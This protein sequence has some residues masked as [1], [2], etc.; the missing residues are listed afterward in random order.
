MFSSNNRYQLLNTG[1]I[2]ENTVLGENPKTLASMYDGYRL[3]LV[4]SNPSTYADLPDTLAALA[5]RR[6][7]EREKRGLEKNKRFV[8]PPKVRP[9][10]DPRI[11]F[12]NK[13]CTAENIRFTVDDPSR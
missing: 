10:S 8:L 11:P 1:D 12:V 5:E 7:V 3:H 9:P 13:W 6:R 2:A 4:Q